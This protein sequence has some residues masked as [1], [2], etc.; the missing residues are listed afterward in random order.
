[1]CEFAVGKSRKALVSNQSIIISSLMLFA[2]P[3]PLSSGMASAEDAGA[4]QRCRYE[5]VEN[6]HRIRIFLI[7]QDSDLCTAARLS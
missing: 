2:Q 7:F 1:M 6:W 4:F 5:S 3:S